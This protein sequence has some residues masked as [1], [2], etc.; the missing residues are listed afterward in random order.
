M[1]TD[2]LIKGE[3]FADDRGTMRFVNAFDMAEVVRFYEIAPKDQHIIRAWQAHKHE[4][5]W[6]HC[7]SGSFVINVVEIDNFEKPSDDLEPIRIEMNSL[8]PEILAVPGGFATGIRASSENAS[9]QV[10][11]NAT[12]EE[13][14]KDDFR[15]PLEKW[16]AE[17]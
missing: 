3:V 4:K 9:L 16:T 11:S 17:W 10:F 13:S 2:L 5:K 14:K 6:F 7:L 8:V 12:L 15:Y 1:H